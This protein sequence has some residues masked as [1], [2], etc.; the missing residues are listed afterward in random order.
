MNKVIK[1][2]IFFMCLPCCAFALNPLS[3]EGMST[4]TSQAGININIDNYGNYLNFEHIAYVDKDGE[5]FTEDFGEDTVGVAGP[6]K[7]NLDDIRVDI[8]RV[9][10]I[11]PGQ[12]T[13]SD[14]SRFSLEDSSSVDNFTH[15]P[16]SIDVTSRLPGLSVNKQR[17]GILIGLP[18]VNI[19]MDTFDIKA[20]NIKTLERDAWNDREEE[21]TIYEDSSIME[22]IPCRETFCFGRLTLHGVSYSVLDGYME[23]APPTSGSGIEILTDDVILHTHIDRINYI[24][25]DGM[26]NSLIDVYDNYLLDDTEDSAHPA[27]LSIRD[28]EIDALR[29]N[30]LAFSS[31][32]SDPEESPEIT[33]PGKHGVQ[34][35]DNMDNFTAGDIPTRTKKLGTQALRIDL[36]SKLPMATKMHPD[37]KE[38]AGAAITLP[39]MEMYADKISIGGIYFDD[40]AY[41]ENQDPDSQDVINDNTS[42][43]N[44]VIEDFESANLSGKLELYPH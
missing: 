16:L 30:S 33:S 40:P 4:V 37:N 34:Y 18:T 26:W 9:N 43:M 27:I 41:P 32:P 11:V 2:L 1:F 12:T 25:R 13:G 36:S 15:S 14:H 10:T 7:L 8:L 24:D 17:P 44:V 5:D 39:S 22:G 23:L 19:Y 42:Y 21:R 31:I 28:V 3:D 35:L 20:I 38:I 6:A 29:I